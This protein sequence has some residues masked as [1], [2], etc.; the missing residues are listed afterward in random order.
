MD[1]LVVQ[2]EKANGIVNA[3]DTSQLELELRPI[4]TPQICRKL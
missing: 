4:L 2:C 1:R 3:N